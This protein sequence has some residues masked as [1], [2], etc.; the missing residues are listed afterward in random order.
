MSSKALALGALVALIFFSG[1]V[2]AYDLPKVKADK[3]VSAEAKKILR[4]DWTSAEEFERKIR[5]ALAEGDL[6][7]GSPVRITADKNHIFVGFYGGNAYFLDKYSIKVKKNS[8]ARRSWS[9][10]IFPIGAGVSAKNSKAT[11]QDFSADAGGIYNS[12][13]RSNKISAVGNEDDRAFLTECFKVGYFYAFG[14]EFD[15]Q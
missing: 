13:G 3:K 11:A 5:A 2:E 10:R 7:A 8:A 15:G 12:H 6:A 1:T 9:Q 14:E 4:S